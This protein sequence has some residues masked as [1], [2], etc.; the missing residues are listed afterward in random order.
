VATSERREKEEGGEERG[1]GPPPSVHS[2]SIKARS[3][4]QI[5]I[6]LRAC[7]HTEQVV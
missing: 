3:Q 5:D 2:Q 4:Y 1:M 7:G 6:W